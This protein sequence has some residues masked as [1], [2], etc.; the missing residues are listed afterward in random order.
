[1]NVLCRLS[2][3]LAALALVT[4][5]CTLLAARALGQA[6]AFGGVRRAACN[7]PTSI[8]GETPSTIWYVGRR[9]A[10]VK[11]RLIER[12]QAYMP[13]YCELIAR[14]NS[15]LNAR[16]L[17]V[18]DGTKIF[19]GCDQHDFISQS[20][21]AWP[22]PQKPEGVP[23]TVHALK[24]NPDSAVGTDLVAWRETNSRIALLGLAY[25]FSNRSEFAAKASQLARVWFLDPATKMN[26]NTKC[27]GVIPG[28]AP[29]GSTFSGRY[30]LKSAE[31][32]ALL[33]NSGLW[34][35]QEQ[36]AFRQWLGE[37]LEW[38]MRPPPQGGAH[39]ANQ[40]TNVG[41]FHDAQIIYYSIAV[42][43]SDLARATIESFKQRRIQ[44]QIGARGE[45]ASETKRY[46]GWG[47]SLLSL[48]GLLTGAELAHHF[49]TNLFAYTSADGRGIG[50]AIEY[51]AT[52]LNSPGT[53]PHSGHPEFSSLFGQN[54]SRYLANREADRLT[55]LQETSPAALRSQY[56]QLLYPPLRE[57]RGP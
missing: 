13:A 28:R 41:I 52:Y 47:Y 43:R 33:D 56:W 40:P 35:V 23:W 36:T 8:G 37:Y 38:A 21:A 32:L 12:D 5:L 49:G 24:F 27:E 54:V 1:M 25:Y 18:L 10:W 15:Y 45:L 57:T 39:T 46:N 7:P 42:G 26:P 50:P 17:T 55:R 14:A 4:S 9:L 11:A 30:V 20:P 22:D 53:W 34:N 6:E 48:D 2:G 51:L 29:K 3:L 19:P 31:G 16:P 44:G